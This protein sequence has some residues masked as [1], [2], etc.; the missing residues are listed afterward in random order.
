[1]EQGAWHFSTKSHKRAAL[2]SYKNYEEKKLKK[3]QQFQ[4]R[5]L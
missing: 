4:T 1:M 2:K 3:E 5:F